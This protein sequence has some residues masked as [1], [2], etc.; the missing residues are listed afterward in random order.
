[1]GSCKFSG[2]SIPCRAPLFFPTSHSPAPGPGWTVLLSRHVSNITSQMLPLVQRLAEW[3]GDPEEARLSLAI[4]ELHLESPPRSKGTSC[5]TL[6][7]TA[8]AQPR[9]S[10]AL[11]TCCLGGAAGH[12]PLE[13]R[14]LQA[15]FCP[16]ARRTLHC[17]PQALPPLL[18][19]LFKSQTPKPLLGTHRNA[20]MGGGNHSTPETHLKLYP[21]ISAY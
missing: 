17:L 20:I 19:A 7:T 1:M 16:G 14:C 2:A 10:R 21:K 9:S 15:D 18:Y 12:R 3:Q 11:G 8:Q 5:L 6:V 4:K 13:G